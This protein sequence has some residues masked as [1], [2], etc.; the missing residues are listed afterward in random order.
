MVGG[1]ADIQITGQSIGNTPIDQPPRNET[2]RKSLP[3]MYFTKSWSKHESCTSLSLEKRQFLED[4]VK[5]K[6]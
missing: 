1:D 6:Y 3:E 2:R 5:W 4:F